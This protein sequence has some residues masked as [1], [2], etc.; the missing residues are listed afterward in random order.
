MSHPDKPRPGLIDR[1]VIRIMT[2]LFPRL[3]ETRQ[4]AQEIRE[5]KKQTAAI[6]RG[7]EPHEEAAAFKALV[8]EKRLAVAG[9]ISVFVNPRPES[10]HAETSRLLRGLASNLSDGGAFLGGAALTKAQLDVSLH[11]LEALAEERGE[12]VEVTWRREAL[13]LSRDA[14]DEPAPE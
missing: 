11:L 6:E 2:T 14:D 1:I 10:D 12:P 4:V 8:R 3:E 7:E 5:L 9:M 13:R